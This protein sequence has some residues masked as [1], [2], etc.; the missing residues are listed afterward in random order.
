MDVARPGPGGGRASEEKSDVRRGL[1]ISGAYPS[2]QLPH[3]RAPV[4]DGG[5]GDVTVGVRGEQGRGGGHV[6]TVEVSAPTSPSTVWSPC[7][8]RYCKHV[9][10]GSAFTDRPPLHVTPAAPRHPRRGRSGRESLSLHTTW[11]RHLRRGPRPVKLSHR[12]SR[13][14]PSTRLTRSAESPP[15][16]PCSNKEC[17]FVACHFLLIRGP[18]KGTGPYIGDTLTRVKQYRGWAR[19]AGGDLRLTSVCRSKDTGTV[20][21]GAHVSPSPQ[22]REIGEGEGWDLGSPKAWGWEKGMGGVVRRLV[23]RR[24][25]GQ[26]MDG[27]K[28]IRF[29]GAVHSSDPVLRMRQVLFPWTWYG[30]QHVALPVAHPCHRL[31]LLP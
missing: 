13:C 24:Q 20:G 19:Q 23:V 22:I 21:P 18:M 1:S 27:G 2:S 28:E 7:D 8:D 30:L 29:P 17:P 26:D 6:P 31:T 10:T 16:H 14:G 9:R 12:S 5:G 15:I 3:A 4:R 11:Q 25:G